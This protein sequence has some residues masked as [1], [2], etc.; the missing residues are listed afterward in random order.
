MNADKLIISG[1][2]PNS[3]EYNKQVQINKR[4]RA[5]KGALGKEI[6]AMGSLFAAYF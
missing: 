3:N 5:I 6:P 2:Y 4:V 1:D